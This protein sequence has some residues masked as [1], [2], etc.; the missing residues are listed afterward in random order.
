MRSN[1]FF[2]AP[3]ALLVAVPACT[4]PTPYRPISTASHADRT[5]YW[6]YRIEPNRYRVSFSGNSVT[7][8]ET[9]ERYLLFRA[10]ELTLQ[11]GF[12]WFVMADRD[13]E[14][15]TRTYVDRPFHTGPYGFWGPHWAYRSPRLGW[16]SWDPYWGDPFWDSRIDIRT[17]DR[18]EASAEIVMGKGRAPN[19]SRTF[20]AR[21][22]VSNLGSGIVLPG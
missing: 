21:A 19:D 9:V 4:A 5:G 14:R 3:L 10:A 18:Y 7:S 17:V 15:R 16:R 22:V 11:Q 8:R 6:D 1:L 13:T 20:D 12:D 2:I